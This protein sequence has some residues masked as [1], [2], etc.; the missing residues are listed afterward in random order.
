MDGSSDH[1]QKCV[2]TVF[3]YEWKVDASHYK[4]WGTPIPLMFWCVL[5]GIENNVFGV[6]LSNIWEIKQEPLDNI[7]FTLSD[8]SSNDDVI[9]IDSWVSIHHSTAS[10]EKCAMPIAS[11]EENSNVTKST[12]HIMLNIVD[13][14]WA[15][16][17]FY[18][19]K[20]KLCHV[21]WSFIVLSKASSLSCIFNGTIL[22]ELPPFGD[23]N[24]FV[25]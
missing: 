4:V 17:K 1:L 14:L 20:S 25:G 13:V 16:N 23:V 7:V 3:G 18:W 22:F 12:P 10:V 5:L 15:F 19:C 21:D 24:S 8:F 9:E 6:N 11:C 2:W